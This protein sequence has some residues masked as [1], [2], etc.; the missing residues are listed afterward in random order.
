MILDKNSG[1]DYLRMLLFV[2]VF[3]FTGKLQKISGLLTPPAT[4]GVRLD[5]KAVTSKL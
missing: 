5:Y 3:L 1:I 2:L 4:S